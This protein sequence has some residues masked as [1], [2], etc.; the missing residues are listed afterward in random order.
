MEEI[1]VIISTGE[2]EKAKTG[3]MYAL[4]AVLQNWM[5]DVKLIFF[6]PSQNLLIQ[7]P[8]VQDFVLQFQKAQGT[9][10][11]CKFLAERDK[12]SEEIASRGIQVESVGSIISDLIKE[13]YIPLI[14]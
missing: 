4:N 10:M 9:I 2:V 14:W 8:E 13:G 11:A 3:L 5:S 12:N 6:G 1:V 7:D